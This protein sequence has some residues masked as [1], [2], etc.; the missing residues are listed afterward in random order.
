MSS[1]TY[2]TKQTSPAISHSDCQTPHNSCYEH[3]MIPIIPVGTVSVS[4]KLTCFASFSVMKTMSRMPTRRTDLTCTRQTRLW[5]TQSC[6]SHCPF[7]LNWY[8]LTI[9]SLYWSNLQQHLPFFM[10]WY[11]KWFKR[12]KNFFFTLHRKDLRWIYH[13]L[14]VTF[15]HCPVLLVMKQAL[16][17]R[18]VVQCVFKTYNWGCGFESTHIPFHESK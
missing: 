9:P 8:Q 16:S 6:S 5:M 11:N 7:C 1:S 10:K 15:P 12:E 17:G 13:H 18:P 3:T 2:A 14:P 4:I